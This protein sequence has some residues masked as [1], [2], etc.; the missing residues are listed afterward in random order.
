[1]KNYHNLIRINL[2]VIFCGFLLFGQ[3]RFSSAAECVSKNNFSFSS[4]ISKLAPIVDRFTKDF[5]IKKSL[6]AAPDPDTCGSDSVWCSGGVAYANI[7]WAAAPA[8]A[9]PDA[10]CV[11]V[12][13]SCYLCYYRLNFTGGSLFPLDSSVT[14]YTLALAS[15]TTYYWSV[16]SYY[17]DS[18]NLSYCSTYLNLGYL[19]MGFND[20]SYLYS[21]PFVSGQPVG[22]FT[23][24]NCLPP[25]AP[26]SLSATLA[27]SPYS[28]NQ[29]NLA[30]VDN[31]TNET[32]YGVQRKTATTDWATIATLGANT[33]SYSN[34][35][36]EPGGATYIYRVYAYNSNGNAYSNEATA[37]VPLC[38]NP[39]SN[40]A[41]NV[42]SCRR[43]ELTWI[44]NSLN[45]S[46]FLIERKA[47]SGGTW[48]QVDSVAANVTFYE[49]VALN[50]AINYY[51]RVRAINSLGFHS[52]YS[53]EADGLTFMCP[54]VDLKLNGS[55][56]PINLEYNSP[57]TL[58]WT[59]Q[60]ATRCWASGD[61]SGSKSTNNGSESLAPITKDM[62]FII[63]CEGQVPLD[64]ATD[65]VDV[66]V[67]LKPWWREIFPW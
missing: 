51:F 44:D 24:P 40:L 25:A 50:Q 59:T 53:N 28:C 35:G 20:G 67:V 42:T 3:A 45:E 29:V 13:A 34:V 66:N 15:N 1:M 6:A 56:G 30:W 27:A 47:G 48:A 65:Q 55:D 14:N 37:A 10:G 16:N 41:A 32:G 64:T 7:A 54:I 46:G 62:S 33:T 5:G 26:T 8:I 11:N 9:S 63:T 52:T 38:I 4:A 39:P 19:V 21:V 57:A 23:T 17:I 36:L 18:G 22:S 61:W 12:G 43:I 49:N 31:A 2:I 60:H 58:T